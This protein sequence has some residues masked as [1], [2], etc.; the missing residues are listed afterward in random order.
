VGENDGWKPKFDADD[1]FLIEVIEN[2][3]VEIG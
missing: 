2:L 1:P 3:L